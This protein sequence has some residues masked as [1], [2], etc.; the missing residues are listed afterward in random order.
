[1]GTPPA[2]TLVV[3][4]LLAGTLVVGVLLVIT[5]SQ[6]ILHVFTRHTSSSYTTK[7]TPHQAATN[8][9]AAVCGSS[10]PGWCA[11]HKSIR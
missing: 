2:G 11:C 4:A 7:H 6:G 5:L 9:E 8:P 10:T 3:G 1:M